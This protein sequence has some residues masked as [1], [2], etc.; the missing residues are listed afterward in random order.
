M[1][2]KKA[3]KKMM[4][5]KKQEMKKKK[6]Q[7][8]MEEDSEDSEDEEDEEGH[9][10]DDDDEQYRRVAERAMGLLWRMSMACMLLG[11]ACAGIAAA[12]RLSVLLLLLALSVLGT[13][14]VLGATAAAGS[15]RPMI[16]AKQLEKEEAKEEEE[17]EEAS[18]C[19]CFVAPS[20]SVSN[21]EQSSAD[22][23]QQLPRACPIP[24]CSS[25]RGSSSSDG[26]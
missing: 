18:T 3:K 15:W 11:F 26:L 10:D 16:H 25:C 22:A 2:K 6:K 17:E 21:T 5:K 8:E 20:C 19:P 1:L 4:K 7:K 9:A 14:F 13:V 24:H 23:Q 12:P